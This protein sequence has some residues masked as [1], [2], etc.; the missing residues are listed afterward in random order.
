VAAA[1]TDDGTML[2]GW[3]TAVII[4]IQRRSAAAPASPPAELSGEPC[5]RNFS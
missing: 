5:A 4:E 1:P 3:S 2:I